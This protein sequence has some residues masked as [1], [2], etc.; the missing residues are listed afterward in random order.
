MGAGWVHME[1][2]S[3]DKTKEPLGSPQQMPCCHVVKVSHQ[4]HTSNTHTRCEKIAT[5]KRARLSD[6]ALSYDITIA[7]TCTAT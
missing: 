7:T 1:P 4:S 6:H 3:G 5:D 2:R